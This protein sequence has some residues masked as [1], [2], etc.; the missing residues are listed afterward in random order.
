[1]FA[2]SISL[3]PNPSNNEATIKLNLD[4]NEKVAVTIF[5]VQGKVVGSVIEK[6][7]EKGE[8]TISLNTSTLSNGV[9]IVQFTAGGKSA[10]LELIVNH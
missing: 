6:Q 8:Q 10:K 4:K 3:F 2:S 5:D 7:L 1:L 9:Y